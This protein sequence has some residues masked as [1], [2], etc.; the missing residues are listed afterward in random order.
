MEKDNLP[1]IV[2]DLKSKRDALSLAH[3]QL[4]KDSDD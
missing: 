2:Q 4:K 1:L 3:E